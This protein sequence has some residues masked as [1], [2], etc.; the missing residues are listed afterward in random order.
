MRQPSGCDVAEALLHPGK[1]DAVEALRF[2]LS[3]AGCK[4][5]EIPVNHRK[6]GKLTLHSAGSCCCS[7]PP[8][9]PAT[10]PDGAGEV[11]KLLVV[12]GKTLQFAYLFGIVPR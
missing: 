11:A 4:A 3:E 10:D 7:P 5:V 9:P 1:P 6:T 8:T 2:T 12:V